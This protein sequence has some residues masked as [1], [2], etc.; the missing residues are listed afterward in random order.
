MVEYDPLINYLMVITESLQE[1]ISGTDTA[2]VNNSRSTNQRIRRKKD[3]L[4]EIYNQICI[5]ESIEENA[6]TAR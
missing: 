5:Q 2:S 1:I 6:G 4:N 3:C